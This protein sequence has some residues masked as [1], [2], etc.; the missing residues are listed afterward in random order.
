[1]MVFVFGTLR[2]VPLLETL[3]GR[4]VDAADIE[5][6]HLP[7][8]ETVWA[9]GQAF[10]LLRA[11]PGQRAEG[12]LLSGLGAQDV[13]RLSYYEEGF[14]Y[15]LSPVTVT[16]GGAPCE[17][18]AWFPPEGQWQPGDAFDL[19][20]WAAR[21]AAINTRA[22]AEVM[23]YYGHRSAAQVAHMYPMI[24]GRAA[25]FIAAQANSA[26]AS[27]S[28]MRRADVKL[29]AL[30]RPYAD[31]FAVEEYHLSFKQFDGGHSP[32]VKRAIFAPTDA[33]LVLPYDPVRDQVLLLEQ[34]RVGPYAHGDCAPWTLEPVAGR[35]DAG[36]TP[37]AAARR[38]AQEEA[39]LNLDKLEVVCRGYPTPGTSSEFYHIFVA[40]ADLGGAAAGLG[41]LDSETED[42]RTHV[43]PAQ[44]FID[45]AD[46]R[47]L[48]VAPLVLCAHWLARHRD[49]L[50]AAS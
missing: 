8:F 6:A 44:R 21:W 37:E 34:F 5:A 16:R 45:M 24:Q 15:T 9:R 32:V 43:L 50:R 25:S 41:G 35:V 19:E 29:K 2:H 14:G 18:R 33:S 39:G 46:G 17:A 47:E 27:F 26:P 38:E 1:M 20:A 42:I 10:P 13:A 7:E 11:A 23:G 40:L 28:G 36:E 49:R 12:L 48:K 31:F 30:E 4:A 22:A 3:L